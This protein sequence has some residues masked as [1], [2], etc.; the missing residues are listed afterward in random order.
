MNREILKANMFQTGHGTH[1]YDAEYKGEWEDWEL[2]TA[3]D[4][5]KWINPT[6]EDLRIG[7][8]G[9]YVRRYGENQAIVHVYYD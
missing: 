3:I 2:I 8:Y 4:N 5:R 1:K 9:G 7:H 6:E